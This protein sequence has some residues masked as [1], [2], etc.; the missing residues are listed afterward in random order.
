MLHVTTGARSFRSIR[1]WDGSKYRAF[2][3]LCYQLRDPTPDGSTLVKTGDPDGGYEWYLT[4]PDGTEWGWQAKYVFDIGTLLGSMDR[5]LRTVV[6]KRPNCRRL[7][8]CIPFDLPDDPGSGSRKSA[9]RRFE[10]RKAK[11]K[12][13]IAGSDQIAI[14]LWSA[15]DLLERL[16]AHPNQRGIEWFFWNEEVFSLD[17][18]Q[19]RHDVNVDAVRQRY[20]PQL[21]VEL[22]ISFALE[23]LGRSPV[24]WQQFRKLRQAV[25]TAAR[26]LELIDCS[27]RTTLSALQ[28]LREHLDDWSR[29]IPE[30]SGPT[31]RLDRP[32]LARLTRKCS[33][34]A[35][36]A[37]PRIPL[38]GDRGGA[39][40][41]SP[42][43]A[44]ERD[45]LRARLSH[46][47]TTLG[48]FDRFVEEPA[49]EAAATGRL[50]VLGEAGQ[51]KTHLFCD[52]VGKAIEC[53]RPAILVLGGQ[54][55]GRDPWHGIAA[56]LGLPPVGSETLIG[57]MQAAAEAAGYPFLLLIDA[58]NES[59]EATVWSQE[60]PS[61][62]AE[63]SGN[64]WISIG[65]SVRS[66]Y[67]S[68][69]LP[70]EVLD[71]VAV[72]QHTGFSDRL[73]EGDGAFLRCP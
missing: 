2:E 57:A 47:L 45:A 70:E 59:H 17:W 4:L 20:S 16:S 24:Y 26:P 33:E 66:T 65:V 72:L 56:S 13:R 43:V 31:V 71:N 9:R 8:F 61:L 51:G 69:V 46:L 39:T 63:V 27:E 68:V 34:A 54:L 50:V 23:G 62:M 11:W 55:H 10:D 48:D 1:E 49:S 7:T 60:L 64:P 3:E 38:L 40:S 28:V 12:D 14:D 52:I 15:G 36:G 25:L 21:H 30:D 29:G 18:L 37:Y 42:E 5:T 53:S 35:S 22:P 41:P 19:K 58:L 67:R 32:R 44:N 6:D 73:P